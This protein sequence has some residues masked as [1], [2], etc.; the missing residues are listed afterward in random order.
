MYNH[1]LDTFQAVVENGSFTRAASQLFISHTAV[2]KQINQLENQLGVTLFHRNHQGLQLTSAG[3]KLWQELPAYLETSRKLL[4]EVQGQSATLLLG[5][6]PFY[7]IDQFFEIW[8][9]LKKP[10]MRLEV[11]PFQDDF[12]SGLKTH[13]FDF[14]IGVFND[15]RQ[16]NLLNFYRLGNYHLGLAVPITNPLAQQ[17]LIKSQDLQSQTVMILRKGISQANDRAREYLLHYCHRLVDVPERYT[18]KTFNIAAKNNY[19][20]LAPDCWDNIQPS[21]TFIPL[22]RS[23]QLPFGIVY[24]QSHRPEI[25]RL[26]RILQDS[27][28][29]NEG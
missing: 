11:V 19:L 24:T 13:Q 15:H 26:I 17:H 28:K 7:P 8:Q 18:F 10:Q 20:L 14:F 12:L 5:S 16:Q 21:L 29:S 25:K 9:Q 27:Q 2:M 6:S 1:L 22:D 4:Q 3:K 23:F